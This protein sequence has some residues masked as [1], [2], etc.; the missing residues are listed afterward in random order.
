MKKLF[1]SV[2]ALS[3][4]TIS[5]NAQWSA[6]RPDGHAPIQVMGDHTHT[7]GEIMISYRYMLMDMDGNGDGT[8]ELSNSE[9]LRNGSGKYMVAPLGMPMEMHMLGVM[10]AFSDNLTLMG[11][12]P[13]LQNSMDHTTA[14]GGSFSTESSGIGDI[15]I[16]A[17][18]NF[19]RNNNSSMHW[20]FGLSIPTGSIEK[21]DDTPMAN[22]SLLPYPM[23]IGSGTFDFKPG[24]TYL[25]QNEF[26]SFGTQLSSTIRLTDNDNDYRK[27]DIYKNT[28]WLGYR[29]TDWLSP[30]VSLTLSRWSD[31]MGSDSRYDMA[32]NS[33][34][35]HTIDPDLKG[36]TRADIGLGL[37]L[38]GP[39]GPLHDLRLAVNYDLPVYQNL[40]GPQMLTKSILT[41][42]LQYTFH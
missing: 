28:T 9:I 39:N 17:L 36:G 10:Y 37:N 40:D 16:S 1:F 22:N 3:L 18:Y 38:K 33:D 8:N 11:M 31:Y 24:V 4:F 26:I 23:Q 34:M 6:G 13:Y 41:F 42:G 32:L 12:L 25:T 21:K 19:Y 5:A 20:Q 14:M 35:V 15:S 2:F 29:L 27:S 7:K 30:Q